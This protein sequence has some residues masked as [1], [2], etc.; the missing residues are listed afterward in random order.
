M[1]IIFKRSNHQNWWHWMPFCLHWKSLP[2]WKKQGKTIVTVI[3]VSGWPTS[4]PGTYILCPGCLAEHHRVRSKDP[5]IYVTRTVTFSPIVKNTVVTQPPRYTSSSAPLPTARI[6][7]PTLLSTSV[8][9]RDSWLGY[10]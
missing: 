6:F 2:M 9:R 4:Y 3:V 8:I 7:A 1:S 5:G 10:R